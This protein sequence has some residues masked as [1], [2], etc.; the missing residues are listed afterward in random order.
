[1]TKQDK[2]NYGSV[3]VGLIALAI[4]FTVSWMWGV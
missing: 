4:V 3:V 2:F 1:M